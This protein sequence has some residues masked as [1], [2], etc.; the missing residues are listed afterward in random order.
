LPFFVVLRVSASPREMQRMLTSIFVWRGVTWKR[1]SPARED[2]RPTTASIPYRERRAIHSS[3]PAMIF[4][5]AAPADTHSLPSA[6]PTPR[7]PRLQRS[8]IPPT[9]ATGRA[10]PAL[11]HLPAGFADKRAALHAS[12]R[13]L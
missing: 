3:P 11:H 1:P 8:T 9:S 5:A 4:L 13:L 7:A 6:H 2:T 12:P 10:E